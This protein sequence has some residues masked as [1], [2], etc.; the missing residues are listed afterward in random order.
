MVSNGRNRA[1]AVSERDG[2]PIGIDSKNGMG[3]IQCT[4]SRVAAAL[5]SVENENMLIFA[6][7]I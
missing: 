4:T 7:G 1:V 3:S 5:V 6:K 2:L